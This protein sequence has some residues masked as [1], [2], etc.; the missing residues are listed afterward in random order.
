MWH[1]Y[2]TFDSFPKETSFFPPFLMKKLEMCIFEKSVF[3]QKLMW[4]S[5]MLHVFEDVC[6]PLKLK[7]EKFLLVDC[8]FFWKRL[9]GLC[10]NT[11]AGMRQN[12]IIRSCYPKLD[13]P[14]GSAF[15]AK[16]SRDK[17]SRSKHCHIRHSWDWAVF[18]P[19]CGVLLPLAFKHHN[20]TQIHC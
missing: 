7:L 5:Q 20:C 3:V 12:A 18:S 11:K 2:C 13:N 15:T 14:K 19:C 10:L 6:P 9:L 4:M 8:Q 16:R 17:A 1:F